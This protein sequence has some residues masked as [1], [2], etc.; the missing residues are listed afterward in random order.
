MGRP[1]STTLPVTLGSGAVAMVVLAVLGF[2]VGMTHAGPEGCAVLAHHGQNRTVSP[3][4][5]VH[6]CHC[7]CRRTVSDSGVAHGLQT[8]RRHGCETTA[9]VIRTRSPQGTRGRTPTPAP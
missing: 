1:I 3:V 6:V 7:G 8:P 2:A 4:D 9:T 5:V